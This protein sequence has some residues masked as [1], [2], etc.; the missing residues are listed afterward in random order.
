MAQLD[1][2]DLKSGGFVDF[3]RLSRE[4][5]EVAFV[6][7]EISA[8]DAEEFARVTDEQEKTWIETNRLFRKLNRE[9][10]PVERVL[11]SL[12]E[13]L[14]TRQGT[15]MA[16]FDQLYKNKDELDRKMDRNEP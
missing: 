6:L 3:Y 11:M 10:T 16:D 2:F 4:L 8:A 1:S 9:R 7:G 15:V 14:E 13:R 12:S 5:N